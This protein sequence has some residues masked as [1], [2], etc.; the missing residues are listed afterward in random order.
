[1]SKLRSIA[2]L[3]A[4]NGIARNILVSGPQMS[5]CLAQQAVRRAMLVNLHDDTSHMRYSTLIKK[6]N[7]LFFSYVKKFRWDQ[8]HSYI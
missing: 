4:F 8:L 1:M 3:R 2:E 6:E 7:K 5:E